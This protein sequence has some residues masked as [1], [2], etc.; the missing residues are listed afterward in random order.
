MKTREKVR[1]T[2]RLVLCGLTSCDTLR[3][4]TQNLEAFTGDAKTG[5]KIGDLFKKKITDATAIYTSS[6]N[7]DSHFPPP[8]AFHLFFL[9]ACTAVGLTAVK[10]RLP[11]SR[12]GE[13]LLMQTAWKH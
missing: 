4:R 8:F 10:K 13:K 7:R 6:K 11:A 2:P 12:D 9:Q 3:G 5:E 1:R